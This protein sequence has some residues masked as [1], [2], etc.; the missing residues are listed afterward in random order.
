[1]RLMVDRDCF[2]DMSERPSRPNALWRV[3][4]TWG[5]F[6]GSA[7]LLL[8]A[9][10]AAAALRGLQLLADLGEIVALRVDDRVVREPAGYAASSLEENHAVPVLALLSSALTHGESADEGGDQCYRDQASRSLLGGLVGV[11]LSRAGLVALV[12]VGLRAVDVAY[13]CSS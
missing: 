7:A 6:K 3:R 10:A 8:L 5:R 12:A 13:G 2:N 9:T 4:P 1:M 11:V